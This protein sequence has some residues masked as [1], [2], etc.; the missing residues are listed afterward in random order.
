MAPIPSLGA[1]LE[2]SY[3]VNTIGYN[4][5]IKHRSHV[6]QLAGIP[7]EPH[8]TV[9]RRNRF[10]KAE[11]ASLKVA[12]RPNVLIGDLP[13][14]GPGKGDDCAIYR[15]LFFHNPGEA[16]FQ[17]EGGFALYRYLFFN[18]HS[19]GFPAIAIQPHSDIPRRVGV[20][21]NTVVTPGRGIRVLTGPGQDPAQ[22]RVVANAVFANT[23]IQG[24]HL[25]RNWVKRFVAAA[26][27]LEN[28]VPDL[29]S[30]SLKPLPGV[31]LRNPS[32]IARFAA[33]PDFDRDYEGRV[34]THLTV[35]A[36]ALP[37]GQ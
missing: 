17:G 3:V 1:V 8:L 4:F 25:G 14:Q 11:G 13:L 19:P 20:F 18:S 35:G 24:G 6:R 37:I 30:M 10:V 28:P 21:H 7:T 27:S 36:Y 26:E 16:L 2:D 15:N 5:Q 22:Q 29:R 23:P 31:L 12:A 32:G 9:I 33:Y 34:P